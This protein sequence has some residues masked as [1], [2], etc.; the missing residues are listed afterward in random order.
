LQTE[1]FRMGG[2]LI[3]AGSDVTYLMTAAHSDAKALRALGATS[4]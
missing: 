4:S 2:R 1:L 3:I